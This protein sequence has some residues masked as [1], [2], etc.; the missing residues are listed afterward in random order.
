[1]IITF[2][3]VGKFLE[4]LSKKS[5]AD[6]LDIMGKDIPNEVTVW[7]NGQTVQKKL[8]DVKEGDVVILSS[9]QKALFDGEVLKGSGSFDESSLTGESEPVYKEVGDKIISA[10]VSID[11]D[12]QY[13]VTKDFEH[14]TLAHLTHLLEEALG[15]KPRIQQLANTL[16]EYFS[17]VILSL[18]LLTFVVWY[19]YLGGSFEHAFMVAISV[20]VIACPC[21]LALATPVATLVG[22]GI[23]AKRGILFKQAAQLETMAKTDV[24]L[25]DKTGTLTYGKP[26]VVDVKTFA[27]Y[28]NDTLY[29]M[30]KLSKHPIS[31]G[32]NRYLEEP[33]REVCF[34]TFKQ[35][36]ALGVEAYV[37]GHRYLGGN[38][39]LMKLFGIE[40]EFEG[41]GSLFFF[42]KDDT[43]VAV[44]ELEDQIKPEAKEIIAQ[45]K[46]RGIEPIIL[47]GDHE[48]A[49]K[50]V[51]EA[52]GIK[53]VYYE[54]S[55]EHKASFVEDMHKQNKKVVM[56]GDGIND[57]LALSQADIGIVMGSGSDIAIEVGDVVLLDDT[58]N[59]LLD[60]FKIAATTYRFVKENLALS[61]LYNAITVP[62]AMAGYVIPLV[63]AI[64]MS[65]SSLL[66]VGNSM[67]ITISWR[68]K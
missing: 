17:A 25:L 32:V 20:I 18:S 29:W 48:R 55:P 34:D 21:A 52:I 5:V 31:Q 57:I 41:E 61:L 59:A 68:K 49:A 33:S 4:V 54:L 19:F 26:E 24:L 14:S 66:V 46:K 13:R 63:A 40:A 44:F 51:A 65:L 8:S 56:V 2:V 67:R 22:L 50:R 53:R 35:H 9:G 64:S 62:L 39:K 16:S 28:D 3:L 7:E 60:A 27:P 30:T 6:A 47:T 42:A 43:L 12:I 1:M 38:A 58:L 10:T 37:D 15:K 45:I 23:A 36:S 11:A